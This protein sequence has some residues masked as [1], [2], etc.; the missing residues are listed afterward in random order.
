[1]PGFIVHPG[2]SFRYYSYYLEG[3]SRSLGARVK[4]STEGMP[5]LLGGKS[6][7]P[8]VLPDGGR[9]F[10]AA[11]DHS[12]VDP[13]WLGWC[14]VY[15]QVNYDAAGA[16]EDPRVIS[17]GPS[18]GVRWRSTPYL[19]AYVI[20][21]GLA[22]SRWRDVPARLRDWGQHQRERSTVDAYVPGESDPDYLFFLASWWDRHPEAN[23]DRVLFMEAASSI[24][25]LTVEGGFVSSRRSLVAPPF[26]HG[27][28]AHSTFLSSTVRSVAVF[29]APA[30]HDCLGWKL[31]EFLAL[32]KA[33]ISVPL[34]RGMPEPLVHGEHIHF[35][36]GSPGSFTEALR[37]LRADVVYR[38]QLEHNARA[39]WERLLAPTAVVNRLVA[40]R[41]SAPG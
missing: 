27:P 41:R 26:P 1:M 35:V 17:I 7:L 19:A 22:S 40:A 18:F 2:S 20:R 13:D 12:T 31:G 9:V 28:V 29:N 33:I 23:A 4:F 10:I 3:F 11:D 15:G 8:V 32:G 34:L 39:Y 21:A 24:P 36:D 16:P 38:K 30:V 6:G 37:L 14:H 5:P 25:S